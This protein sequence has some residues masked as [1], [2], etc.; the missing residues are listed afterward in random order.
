MLRV[1]GHAEVATRMN[2]AV[3]HLLAAAHFALASREVE[4]ENAGK[5]FGPHFDELLWTVS[6]CVFASV[7]GLEAYANEVFVDRAET[8][9]ELDA[10]VADKIWELCERRPVLEKFDAI[11][12][13]RGIG[14]LG[15]GSHGA[16]DVSALVALR[17]GLIH[18]KPQWDTEQA[19]HAKISRDLEGRFEPS[20]LIA[21]EPIFPR[22]WACS[23]CAVWA[24]GTARDFLLAVET[25]AGLPSKVGKHQDKLQV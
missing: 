14:P 12:R 18:F 3:Q 13:L 5:P 21:D 10:D 17:N 11:Y 20:T 6:A 16:Q 15:R 25:S 7:A 24:L 2:F 4:R 9:P 23:S 8:L 19:T 1:T 22:R